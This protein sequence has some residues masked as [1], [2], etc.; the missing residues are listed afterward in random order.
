MNYASLLILFSFMV[1]TFVS[2]SI[3]GPLGSISESYYKW[4]ARNFSAAFNIFGLC[5][6]AGCIGQTFYDY[7]QATMLFFVLSGACVWFLTVASLY[8]SQSTEHYLPTLFSIVF[9]YAAVLSEYGLGFKFYTAF[10][11]FIGLSMVL[12]I[13]KVRY[14]TTWAELLAMVGVLYWFLWL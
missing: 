6:F 2:W 5:V 10:G 4:Q 13:A 12:K 8:K 1:Y 11:G 14:F 9:G 7:K 3:V